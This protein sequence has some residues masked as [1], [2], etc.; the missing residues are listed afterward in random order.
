MRSFYREKEG[1]GDGEG[2]TPHTPWTSIFFP[3]FGNPSRDALSFLAS[4]VR[5][6]S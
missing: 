1:K 3:F 6:S 2:L 5:V 4:A